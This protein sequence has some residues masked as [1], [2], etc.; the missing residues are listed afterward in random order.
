VAAARRHG[1]EVTDPRVVRDPSNVLVHLAPASVVA[2]VATTTATARPDGARAWLVRDVAMAGWLHAR[3]AA[4]VAPAHELPPGPHDEDGFVLTFWRLVEPQ[5]QR[6]ADAR[7][8][9]ELRELHDQLDGF[10]GALAPLS[11]V[12]GEAGMLID[13]CGLNALREPLRAAREVLEEGDWPARPL[14]GDAHAGNLLSTAS[15]VLWTDF[16]DCCAGPAEWDLACLVFGSADGPAALDAYGYKGDPAAVEAFVEARALQVAAWTAL[17][18]EHHPQ[19]RPSLAEPFIAYSQDG[20]VDEVFPP[21]GERF[22]TTQTH[23]LRIADGKAIEHWANRDDLG[24]AKQ[25][26]WVPPTP[27]YLVRMALAKRRARRGGVT[28]PA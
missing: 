8:G 11:S 22:A 25:L 2:R 19:L 23:W 20:S 6:P 15:G 24:T 3:A 27:R 26:G 21:T 7:A 13:H 18:A 4:V 14:H 16:E 17:M 5:A 1:L 28:S 9:R 10:P 12:L